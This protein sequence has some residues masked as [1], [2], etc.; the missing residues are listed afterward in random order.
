MSRKQDNE[1]GEKKRSKKTVNEMLDDLPR[2]SEMRRGWRLAVINFCKF[3]LHILKR[4]PK[5]HGLENCIKED[6]VVMIANHLSLSEVFAV[7]IYSYLWPHWVAKEELFYLP[8]PLSTVVK[9]W[10]AVPLNRNGSDLAAARLMIQFLKDGRSLA[11]F[12]QGTR[13]RTMDDIK[14]HLPKAGVYSLAKKRGCLIQ[15]ISIGGSEGI[16]KH[17]DVHFMPAIDP[18]TFRTDLPNDELR[19]WALFAMLYRDQE[20]IEAANF[21][22]TKIKEAMKVKEETNKKEEMT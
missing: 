7:S 18:Q 13:C 12:P 21:F 8:K 2:P 19:I 6:P 4:R 20:N 17:L 16:G 9:G 10:G 22:E 5:I 3:W 11:V 15:P 14:E 1:K